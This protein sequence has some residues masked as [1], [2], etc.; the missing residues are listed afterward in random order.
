M[1]QNER[2]VSLKSHIRKTR[3][4]LGKLEEY[5][6]EYTR[7][8]M[9][10]KNRKRS[11]AI[12]LSDIFVN[13]YTC[14][15]TLFHRISQSFEN[16]LRPERWHQDLLE[17]MTIE[18]E[19]VR[20]AVISDATFANLQELL[21]FRHFKRY[22]YELDYDWEK[23]EFLMKKFMRVTSVIHAELD[24]FSRFLDTLA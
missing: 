24:A 7:S 5:Y 22:Y 9:D 6:T 23:I 11:D 2:M 8:E 12:V 20:K 18:I 1:P 3:Q 14:L 10:P 19:G 21:K 16:E 4:V 17:K 15:E 13:Y